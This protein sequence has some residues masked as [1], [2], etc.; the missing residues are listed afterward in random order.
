MMSKPMCNWITGLI[1]ELLIPSNLWGRPPYN[2]LLEDWNY[3]ASIDYFWKGCIRSLGPFCIA[4]CSLKETRKRLWF[5]IGPLCLVLFKCPWVSLSEFRTEEEKKIHYVLRC[6]IPITCV[7]ICI[8]YPAMAP[9]TY[10]DL[11]SNVSCYVCQIHCSALYMYMGFI[12][13]L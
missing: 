11:I 9:I 2:V 7:V 3:I 10:E 4:S 5:L 6:W 13:G 12:L 8:S 1:T